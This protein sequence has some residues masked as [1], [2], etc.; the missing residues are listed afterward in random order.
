MAPVMNGNNAEPTCPHP[1][2]QPIDPVN[3]RFERQW[4][5]DTESTPPVNIQRGNILPAWFMEI[6]YIGP[7]SIPMKAMETAPPT[8]DGTNHTT[9]SKPIARKE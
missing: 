3:A 9:N 5:I 8:R 7:S 4:H 2:I 1:A 6:G